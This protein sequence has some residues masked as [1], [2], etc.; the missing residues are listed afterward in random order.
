MRMYAVHYLKEKRRL[1]KNR[2]RYKCR[3]CSHFSKYDAGRKEKSTEPITERF[4]F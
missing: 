1:R 4:L 2:G 3:L